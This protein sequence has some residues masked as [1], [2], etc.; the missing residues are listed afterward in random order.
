MS[1]CSILCLCK[2]VPGQMLWWKV[3]QYRIRPAVYTGVLKSQEERVARLRMRREMAIALVSNCE[4]Q[5]KWSNAFISIQPIGKKGE[6]MWN[7][8]TEWHPGRRKIHLVV[9]SCIKI[10]QKWRMERKQELCCSFAVTDRSH[11][12]CS[13]QSDSFTTMTHLCILMKG[14]WIWQAKHRYSHITFCKSCWLSLICI[15]KYCL[16][17][18][19]D[20]LSGGETF[21][22]PKWLFSSPL[23]WAPQFIPFVHYPLWT[24]GFFS[25]GQE[26]I[27]AAKRAKS[28]EVIP[29]LFRHWAI[30]EQCGCWMFPTT[31]TWSSV[32]TK[33]W[34]N[35]PSQTPRLHG[36]KL[37]LWLMAEKSVLNTVS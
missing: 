35:W 8:M 27:T 18:E 3:C 1:C 33:V 24:D 30:W 36:L 22:C 15:Q 19:R 21:Q 32:A 23:S 20:G 2:A 12:A 31:V 10:R 29:L 25:Y 7:R 26:I 4:V 14:C 34:G 28:R 5:Q 16:C 17:D 13:V 11:H 9:S 37:A 6:I